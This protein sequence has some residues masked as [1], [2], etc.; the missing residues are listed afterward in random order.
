MIKN[1]P[2][3]YLV[4]QS[5][6]YRIRIGE[7]KCHFKSKWRSNPYQQYN[8]VR[9]YLRKW[10]CI[11][12]NRNRLCQIWRTFICCNLPANNKTAILKFVKRHLNVRSPNSDILNLILTWSTLF[13]FR[14]YAIT[15]CYYRTLFR[16]THY[17]FLI[18]K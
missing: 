6:L 18:T 1:L 17:C 3:N 7:P 12:A 15:F 16:F 11:I 13:L 5:F 4:K 14:F 2:H 8:V 10:H 9:L